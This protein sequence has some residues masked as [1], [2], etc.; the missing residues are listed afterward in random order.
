VFALP[1]RLK[2]VAR[3]ELAQRLADRLGTHSSGGLSLMAQD[4]PATGASAGAEG[5]RRLALEGSAG[6]L[7]VKGIQETGPQGLRGIYQRDTIAIGGLPDKLGIVIDVNDV[8]PTESTPMRVRL[9]FKEGEEAARAAAVAEAVRFAGEKFAA[10]MQKGTAILRALPLGPLAEADARK[11][12]RGRWKPLPATAQI[13][14]PT[15]AF[16]SFLALVEHPRKPEGEHLLV[17][18]VAGAE[19]AAAAIALVA[20]DLVLTAFEVDSG[21]DA[22][23]LEKAL[24][25]LA[26][27]AVQQTAADPRPTP[28]DYTDEPAPNT[29]GVETLAFVL[30]KPAKVTGKL[31]EASHGHGLRLAAV[32]LDIAGPDG[33]TV[34]TIVERHLYGLP[35]E[36]FCLAATSVQEGWTNVLLGLPE[37]R[38]RAKWIEKLRAAL[39]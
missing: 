30:K 5:V 27:E 31:R 28:T 8:G 23:A 19:R 24:A 32:D 21:V 17:R 15:P 2:L 20:P 16:A 34:A 38:H 11:W 12:V 22:R 36:G 39:K 1:V 7:K 3:R 6:E 25:M 18:E 35:G 14:D 10:A 26:W 4:T 13:A 9:D 29:G 33:A 37:S